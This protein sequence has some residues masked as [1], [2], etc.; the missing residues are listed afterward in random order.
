[1]GTAKVFWNGNAQ[2]IRL[3]ED[4]RLPSETDEV[5]VHREGRR[6]VLEPVQAEEWPKSFW[7][8]FEG[9][10]EDF[11]RPPWKGQKREDL[12]L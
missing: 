2:T 12:D 1:M 5:E 10:P 11:E 7:R 8:A 3:P 4:V 6:I 9:M